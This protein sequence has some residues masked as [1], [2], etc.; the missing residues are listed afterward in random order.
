M[1]VQ[2]QFQGQQ[3]QGQQQ[4]L[5]QPASET[6]M[7]A[8]GHP[9]PAQQQQQQQQ[10]L[11]QQNF[12]GSQQQQHAMMMEQQ[13]PGTPG[14]QQMLAPQQPAEQQQSGRMSAIL[15]LPVTQSQ[16]LA[17][18]QVFKSQ[19][20]ISKL[21]QGNTLFR[22]YSEGPASS[23]PKGSATLSSSGALP[24]QQHA[25]DA[26]DAEGSP[27]G[28]GDNQDSLFKLFTAPQSVP[29]AAGPTSSSPPPSTP[30]LED[31]LQ[32]LSCDWLSVAL[33]VV[34]TLCF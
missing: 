11:L 33:C 15:P 20:T 28:D 30:V 16:G 18:G 13:I 6:L 27:R 19:R 2:V 25:S 10:P 5:M 12:V 21:S 32:D 8:A 23:S 14:A 34:C 31:S 26:V 7:A 22:L 1:R 4:Q 17:N 3:F 9:L 29:S 24:K